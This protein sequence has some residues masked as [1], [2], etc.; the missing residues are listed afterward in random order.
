VEAAT[1]RLS[2]LT[3]SIESHYGRKQKPGGLRLKV[4]N[5][6]LWIFILKEIDYFLSRLSGSIDLILF[7]L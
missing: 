4:P 5:P 3:G 6:L 1:G 7:Q 2:T